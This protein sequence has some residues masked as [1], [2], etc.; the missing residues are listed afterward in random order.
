[1]IERDTYIRQIEQSAEYIAALSDV[2]P[3]ICVVLGSG[4]GKLASL[5]KIIKEVSYSDIPGFPV[6]TAPGHAGKLYI[7]EISGKPCY[8]LGGRFHFYE[9]Y[10]IETVTFY[11]RV[12]A[13]L[14]IKTLVLTNAAGG[15]ADV[16][17]IPCL[18]II[19]DHI[20]FLAES[21]LR[22]PNLDEFGVRFPDMSEVYSSELIELTQKIA[23]RIGIDL[24]EGVY[25]A[26]TGPT[27]ET[28][29]EIRMAKIIGADA[30]GMSTVPEAIVAKWAGMNVLGISCICNSAAGVSNVALSHK[31]VI[32]AANV[33]KDRFKRLVKEVIK[34][35]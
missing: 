16:K 21:P 33:A 25:M 7:S 10:D 19:E 30:V 12:M 15:I 6:S 1:M 35:I 27:Y 13:K 4:L 18:M 24:Q 29:A 32:H 22:G 8:L 3:E 2:H 23:D 34:I 26:M 11:V 14:G 9:G 31:D 17:E 5:C 20:S 28:P